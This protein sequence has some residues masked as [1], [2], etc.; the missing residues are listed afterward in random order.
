LADYLVH[1]DLQTMI[2]EAQQDYKKTTAG[3]P[4][5]LDQKDIA[6]RFRGPRKAPDKPTS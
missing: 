2:D 5:L 1:Y 3:T 4:R 6:A